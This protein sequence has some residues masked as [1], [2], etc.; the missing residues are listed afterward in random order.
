MIY[1]K[2]R[3]KYIDTLKFFAIFSVITLHIFLI[4]PNAQSIKY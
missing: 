2:T 1:M 4:W 3:I